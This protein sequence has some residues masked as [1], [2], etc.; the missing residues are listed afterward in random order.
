MGS[1]PPMR[2]KV[3]VLACF[4]PLCR[5]TPAYAGKREEAKNSL[6]VEQDHPRLC[7]EKCGKAVGV[8]QGVGSPPPMRGKVFFFDSQHLRIRITPAYAGKSSRRFF[9]RSM[10]Q[11]HP[12]L[13][14]E[15]ISNRS[16]LVSVIGS[17]PPMRGKES[18]SKGQRDHFG[19]TP[20]YAGKSQKSKVS[21]WVEQDHPR[22]CGEKHGQ[23]QKHRQTK[24]SPP[25][26]R[27]KVNFARFGTYGLGITPAYAGKSEF[28]PHQPDRPKDHPR[29]CGE[30]FAAFQC[31]TL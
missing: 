19:I 23:K 22:L 3:H 15:K 1:P 4:F 12:R 31:G 17:P 24:G 30:K 25:P 8:H 11:D 26:M 28:L 5:I 14:G 21:D 6:R 2:G 10:Y 7:G 16:D 20:A 13:C 27:G 9:A 18:L 29:L